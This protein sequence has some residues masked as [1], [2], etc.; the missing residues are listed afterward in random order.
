MFDGYLRNPVNR[1]AEPVGSV[2]QKIGVSANA[3]TTLGIA[4]A[5]ATAWAIATGRLLL[6]F[7][8]L[9]ATGLCDLLD[10]PVAKA[11]GTSSTQGAFYDSVAD[12]FTDVALLG[13]IAWY[14]NDSRDSNIYFLAVAIMAV[15]LLISYQRAKAESLGLLG[16]GGIM[17]RAERFIVLA[18][19]LLI[20]FLLIPILWVLLVLVSVTALQ[21]FFMVWQ[22][23]KNHDP[24]SGNSTATSTT[25]STPALSGPASPTSSWN[26]SYYLYKTGTWAIQHTPKPI[27]NGG[28]WLV[29]Q[30]SYLIATR[31][32]KLL[33]SHLS[34]VLRHNRSDQ[35]G[36][37]SKRKVATAAR[38]GFVTYA[39]YYTAT[40]QLQALSP[41]EID[42]GFSSDGWENIE[43]ARSAHSVELNG[44]G[45]S[46]SDNS[47]EAK[48]RGVIIALP[49]LG[50]W[51]WAGFWL[52]QI[53]KIP[54][55][56]VVETP[57]NQKLFA[58]MTQFRQKL[59]MHIIP[60]DAKAGSAASKALADGHILCLLC[61]RDIQGNGVEV[62]FFGEKTTLPAG[63]A[64]LALRSG[65]ALLPAAVY[66]RDNKQHAIA[67]PPI[68][69]SRRKNS[70]FRVEVQSVTQDLAHKLE[71]L[72]MKAPE[73]WHLMSPNWPSD[74]EFAKRKP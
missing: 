33:K 17:E 16:K 46:D 68:D 59:D 52:T 53:P 15:S 23:A 36:E 30:L 5:I 14:L 67:F 50:N 29:A 56:V 8:L 57:A 74:V 41:E 62:D 38:Q 58:W 19:G 13:G 31:K 11:A 3:L 28:A 73:Q 1:M 9:I 39:R 47:S 60:L 40:A 22:Q 42:A 27:V 20:D 32:R 61:D 2:L 26:S 24:D 10:G 35:F 72:I 70:K 69:T 7:F 48:P 18:A 45:N 6:G 65:V 44:S 51:E 71:E 4:S 21:R 63:P 34:R 54:V 66:F 12:R 43:Q 25:D 64:T 49:H 37:L 55:S